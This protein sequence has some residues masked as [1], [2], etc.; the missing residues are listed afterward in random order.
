MTMKTWKQTIVF[1]VCLYALLASVILL[2]RHNSGWKLRECPP[3]LILCN[4]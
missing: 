4:E 3:D 1:F 2:V